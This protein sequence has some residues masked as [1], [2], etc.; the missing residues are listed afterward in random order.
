MRKKEDVKRGKK[1]RANN[2]R[3]MCNMCGQGWK[4]SL[5]TSRKGLRLKYTQTK[6]ISW[7][8]FSKGTAQEEAKGLPVIFDTDLPHSMDSIFPVTSLQ[9]HLSLQSWILPKLGRDIWRNWTGTKLQVWLVSALDSCRSGQ[10]IHV[11]FYKISST[12]GWLSTEWL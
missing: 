7:M 9:F 12:L 4:I 6:P 8:C 1:K 2:S 5:A 10:T 11:G 3:K